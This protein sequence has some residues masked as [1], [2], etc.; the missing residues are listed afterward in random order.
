LIYFQQGLGEKAI[1]ER[2]EATLK[3]AKV[4]GDAVTTVS[5]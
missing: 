5:D 2:T 4:T 3:M 1:A